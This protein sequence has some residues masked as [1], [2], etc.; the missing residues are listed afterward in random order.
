MSVIWYELCMVY[1]GMYEWRACEL[2]MSINECNLSIS[3]VSMYVCM[4]VCI[5]CMMCV[6]VYVC[7]CMYVYLYVCISCMYSMHGPHNTD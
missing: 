6:Y 3:V 5:V 7:V 2:G 1:A 4:Y